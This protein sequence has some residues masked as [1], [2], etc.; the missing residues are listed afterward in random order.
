M[1]SGAVRR[2]F[3]VLIAFGLSLGLEYLWLG[4]EALEAFGLILAGFFVA[5]IALLL[6][7]LEQRFTNRAKK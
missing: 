3:I 6:I 1:K 4:R 2:L 5:P 7:Y